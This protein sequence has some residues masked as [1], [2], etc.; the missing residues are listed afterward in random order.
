M[1]TLLA[2]LVVFTLSTLLLAACD[3]KLEGWSEVRVDKDGKGKSIGTLGLGLRLG[4]SNKVEF[5]LGPDGSIF[6]PPGPEADQDAMLVGSPSGKWT[7]EKGTTKI[8]LPRDQH[9]FTRTFG[10]YENSHEE[11]WA[12]LVSPGCSSLTAATDTGIGS[13][14]TVVQ[15]TYRLC[16]VDRAVALL[17]VP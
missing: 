7:L 8:T 3:S 6:A 17:R 14:G 15:R 1:R 9:G 13:R 10:Y 16:N 11:I 5:S 4:P 12:L 2:A